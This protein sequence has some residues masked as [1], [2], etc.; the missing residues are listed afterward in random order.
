MAN[1]PTPTQIQAQYFQILQSLKPSINVNDPNSDFV[2]RGNVFAAFVSGVY[3]D[4]AK[5]DG[6]T[7]FS[8]ARPESLT[9]HGLD[10]NLPQSPATIA[11]SPGVQVTG[12]DGTIVNPGDLSLVYL[13][14]GLLYTN[15]TG[16]TVSGGVLTVSAQ[17][18]SAGQIGNV[19]VG[20]TL[21][22]VSPPTGIQTTA[23]LTSAMADGAD[24][25]TPDA[26]RSR[27]LN[28]LQ[29]PPSGGN[30]NDYRNFAFAADPS[31]RTALVRRF[32]RGL[33]TVDIYIT[34]GTTDIDTAVTQGLS[35]VRVP[36]SGTISTVQ[37]YYNAQAPITDCPMVYG[38]TQINQN[39]TL[40]I[41]L[42]ANVL[43]TTV[44]SDPV[45][46]PLGL[47]VAQL[48]VREVGRALYKVPVGGWP[49]PGFTNGFVIAAYIEQSLDVWLS[50]E[51]DPNTGLP[52]GI[53]PVL[54]DR[55]VQPLN[56]PS[57]NQSLTGNQIVAPGTITV[58]QGT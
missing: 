28:R 51:V 44:P 55:Q 24:A 10:L 47:D 29:Q 7:Y 5:V 27:L 52:I 6:D 4:Q 16:G 11:T 57:T 36:S 21:Q 54:A 17:A 46:N 22:I 38:P 41:D 20:S 39:V 33:G 53:I 40:K 49:I 13:P 19:S 42:A 9:L 14:T 2:I 45:N 25:E 26:Y 3:G 43:L 56:P 15:T 1:F 37:A 8:T 31:V 34:T 23:T 18:N 12:T 48:I 58:T 32:G 30:A 50:A 35:I